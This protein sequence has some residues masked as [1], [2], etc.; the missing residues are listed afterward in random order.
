MKLIDFLSTGKQIKGLSKSDI[1]SLLGEIETL[2]AQL[3]I[4]I[5]ELEKP[6]AAMP[7]NN[8]A[9][10]APKIA[11]GILDNPTSKPQGRI[12]G[13][14]DVIKMTGLSRSTIW[15]MHK[16]G[17]FPRRRNLGPRCVGWLDT[18]VYAWIE[19]RFKNGE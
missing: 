8:H 9:Q 11:K 10:I 19:G 16:V 13:L 3:W 7:I 17:K 12:L 5:T 15:K 6:D 18:E 14:N 4:L 1:P 2:R